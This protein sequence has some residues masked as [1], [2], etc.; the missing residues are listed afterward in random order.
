MAGTSLTAAGKGLVWCMYGLEHVT[1]STVIVHIV[2]EAHACV[3]VLMKYVQWEAYTYNPEATVHIVWEAQAC[4]PA[5]LVCLL[6]KV[7]VYK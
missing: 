3:P 4:N 6:R 1:S 2:W 7:H 5:S